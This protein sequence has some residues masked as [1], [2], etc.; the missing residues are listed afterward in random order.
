M[1]S[2][3]TICDVAWRGAKG[4]NLRAAVRD[5]LFDRG[6]SVYQAIALQVVGHSP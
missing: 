6:V 3:N 4:F 5:S 2:S 1:L